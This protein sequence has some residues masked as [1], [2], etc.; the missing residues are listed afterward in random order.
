ML[1][2]TLTITLDF[3]W[4]YRRFF[5][6]LWTHIGLPIARG[7]APLHA[8]LIGGLALL[9]LVNISVSIISGAG[10][11]VVSVG[12]L[13]G[14]V[15]V[16]AGVASAAVPSL[17]PPGAAMATTLAGAVALLGALVWMR[18]RFGTRS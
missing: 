3:D 11:P 13:L 16:Q 14:C 4:F 7:L 2:R 8:W 9:T 10:R 17:G 12:I 6:A 1:K 15:V 18:R 5:P